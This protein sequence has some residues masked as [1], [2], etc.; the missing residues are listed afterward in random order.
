MAVPCE[1][2]ALVVG[3][4]SIGKRHAEILAS[5]SLDLAIVSRYPVSE[6]RSYTDLA[7]GL[8]DWEPDY[9]VIA[10][11]T[12][13]HMAAINTLAH[14]GYDGR[15]LVEKPFADHPDTFPEG[16]F[17]R[18]SVGYNLRFHPLLQELKQH[19][20]ASG[21]IVNASVYVG[22][23]LPDWRPGVDYRATSSSSRA[24]GGGVLRDISHEL[25][26]IQWLLGSWTSLCSAGGKLSALEI[27]SDDV[28]SILM[29]CRRCPLVTVQLNYL[30]R[31]P[32][33]EV[34]VN[35]GR[36]TFTLDLMANTLFIDRDS[37][38]IE[39]ARND[40]YRDQHLAMLGED[41]GILC[42]PCCAMDTV[43]LIEAIEES[44]NKA[45]WIH[46]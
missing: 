10:N 33:R 8:S 29:K 37:K 4:G 12:H 11:R 7:Q 40:T 43:R 18:F 23:Y 20:D 24:H 19:V 42:S 28:F 35:T 22:S 1:M 45:A 36:G 16:R 41:S 34:I 26:Y 44:A 5:L 17:S 3:Y 9:V 21:P 25:D 15:V 13:Q 39:I 6:F 2:K 30:D 32:R 27:E 46:R 38:H 31:R 14:L